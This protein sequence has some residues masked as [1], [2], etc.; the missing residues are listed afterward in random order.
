MLIEIVLIIK[1]ILENKY[2]AEIGVLAPFFLFIGPQNS[3]KIEEMKNI[4]KRPSKLHP[5]LK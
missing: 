1:A 5:I 3:W 4:Y 2:F